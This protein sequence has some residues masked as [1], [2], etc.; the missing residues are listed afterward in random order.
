MLTGCV[1]WGDDGGRWLIQWDTKTAYDWVTEVVKQWQQFST[2]QGSRLVTTGWETKRE[3][4]CKESMEAIWKVG[5]GLEMNTEN[6]RLKIRVKL[7]KIAK[8]KKIEHSRESTMCGM[9]KA[10]NE[11]PSENAKKGW[12]Q[13]AKNHDIIEWMAG[14]DINT[15]QMK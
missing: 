7:Q 8:K 4:S 10:K 5:N 15:E 14:H 13:N 3:A 12:F 9:C 11:T 2:I 1:V 6:T